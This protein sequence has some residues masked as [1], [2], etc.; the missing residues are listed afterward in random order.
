MKCFHDGLHWLSLQYDTQSPEYDA[1][2]SIWIHLFISQGSLNDGLEPLLKLVA[3]DVTRE[4]VIYPPDF[5]W[6]Y[7]PYDGGCDIIAPSTAIRDQF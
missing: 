3:D 5:E 1:D 7:H 4:V 6:L 2:N